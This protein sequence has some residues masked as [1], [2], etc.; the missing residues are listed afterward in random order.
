[1]NLQTTE[2]TPMIDAK[3]KPSKPF[4]GVQHQLEDTFAQK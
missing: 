3:G 1:M 4:A 2:L